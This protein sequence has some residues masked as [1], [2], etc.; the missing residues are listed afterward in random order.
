MTDLLPVVEVE[1]AA[2]P[3][4]AVIWLHGLG[5]DG[6]DFEALVP[7]LSL[8]EGLAVRFVFPHA[9][10]RPVTINGGMPMRAWYDILEMTLERKVDM[11]NIQESAQQVEDLIQD[12]ISKGISADRIILAGFSQGGVIAYQVGLHTPHVLGG[13]MALSTYLV[14]SDKVP[15]AEFCPNGKTS[16]LIHHGSQDPVVAPTLGAQ[17]QA[18]LTSKGYSVTYQTY[19]MPHAVCPEQVQDIS[20]WL[21][22]QLG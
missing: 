11:A 16:F 12:Q 2:K 8:Q 13:V 6:H 3:D 5:A 21:N 15:Q 7:A 20:A 10:Q 9:P 17:A 19:D 1:T 22:A 14:N 18:N 4:A